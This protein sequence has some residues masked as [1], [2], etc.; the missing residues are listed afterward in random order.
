MNSKLKAPRIKHYIDWLKRVD[1]QARLSGF[2]YDAKTYAYLDEVF[3]LL[4]QVKPLL[5]YDR[6]AWDLWFKAER[7]DITDFGDY[8]E[9]RE[10]G[11]VDNYEEF[12]K[13]WLDYFPEKTSW[14]DFRAIDDPEIGYRAIFLSNRF[15]I[16]LDSRKEKGFENDISEF[17]EWIRDCVKTCID[18]IR[19]GSYNELI[20]RELPP[21]YKTGTIIRR[22]LWDIFPELRE[23]FFSDIPQADVVEFLRIMKTS[24]VSTD[25]DIGRLSDFTANDFYD[26]CAIGYK[27]IGFDVEGLTPR[28]QYYKF[29]DGR[30]DE[31]G[32]IAPDSAESFRKWYDDRHRCGGHPWEV[33]RGGN[34]THISLFVHLDDSGAYLRVAGSAVGR[35]IETIKIYLALLRAGKPVLIHDAPELAARLNETEKIGV[36]PEGVI[37]CY[38]ASMFPDEKIIAF[39]NLP[40][41]KRNEVARCCVWQ[42]LEKVA[43]VESEGANDTGRRK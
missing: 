28:Q 11:D 8:D 38:C 14:Y 35:T 31:L 9:L 24:A 5:K 40:S 6:E 4:K 1:Y 17:A 30:D 42:P 29:A 36:V 23:D 21:Q 33:C 15:V 34:S 32:Q 25:E 16:E 19:D 18:A 26:C 3:E 27:A 41:E 13:L 12:E 7:G 37:P 20:E 43:L 39:I 10:S 22:Q 2:T